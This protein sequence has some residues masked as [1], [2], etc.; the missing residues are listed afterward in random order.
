MTG[1]L[2]HLG[3]VW[4]YQINFPAKSVINLRLQTH[5]VSRYKPAP[6]VYLEV[7]RRLGVAPDRC[8]AFDDAEGGILAAQRA[9]MEVVDVRMFWLPEQRLFTA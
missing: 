6:D 5:D 2:K 7:A 9:G 3:R 1:N 4:E 8:C